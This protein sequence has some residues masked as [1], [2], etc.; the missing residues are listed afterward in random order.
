[1]PDHLTN[2]RSCLQDHLQQSDITKVTELIADTGY[3]GKEIYAQLESANIKPIIPP[4][5]GSP[6]F[7]AEQISSRQE[8]VNYINGSICTKVRKVPQNFEEMVDLIG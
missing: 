2:D 1:M 7:E 5:R 4:A 6:S 3:D 8:T